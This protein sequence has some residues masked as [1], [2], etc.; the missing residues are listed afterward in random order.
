[1][2][3]GGSAGIGRAV[4]ETCAAAGARVIVCA[5]TGSA[6]EDT[7][8]A[9]E[10]AAP[11]G[12][13]G[14]TLDVA[15]RAQ[16]RAAARRAAA[17][18]GGIDG[19]VNCAGILGPIG[20]LADLDLDQVLATLEVNL[21]GTIA[22]CQAFLPLLRAAPRK[23]VVNF[24][25]GGAT[26]VFP[27]YTAYAASKVAVVRFTE[28]LAAEEP[29]LDANC[30]APGFVAT[31]IHQ[32]TL[33]VGASKAG[34]DYFKSTEKQLAEGGVPPQRA[35]ALTAWLL[36]PGSDGISGRLISAPWDPWS[37]PE[38]A[39]RL[40]RDKDLG[41]LRRIDDKYFFKRQGDR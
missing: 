35:A 7:R 25:G 5:R 33:E 29:D 6:V 24:S 9:L 21:L 16:I 10:A 31:R 30:V 22:M 17:E 19:L 36:G 37:D 32:A 18:L 1:L 34:A 15:D 28:N 20:A 11:R 2:I 8:A 3:T 12:H 13:L 40:R 27:R 14:W 39:A 41:T 4:A 23:K 26:A 38:F